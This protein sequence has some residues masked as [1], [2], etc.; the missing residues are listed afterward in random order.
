M[1]L[2]TNNNLQTASKQLKRTNE[3]SNITI[4]NAARCGKET[5]LCFSAW[6]RSCFCERPKYTDESELKD[7]NQN[8][9]IERVITV[10]KPADIYQGQ[11]QQTKY[12]LKEANSNLTSDLPLK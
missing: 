3:E 4:F 7:L 10:A 9:F 12:F 2:E 6:K 5:V 8:E 11:L 1:D